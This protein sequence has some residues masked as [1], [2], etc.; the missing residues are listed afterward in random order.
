MRLRN[1]LTKRR[2]ISENYDLLC[3]FHGHLQNLYVISSTKPKNVGFQDIFIMNFVYFA[4]KTHEKFGCMLSV[5][6]PTNL[7]KI[8]Q[9]RKILKLKLK[10]TLKMSQKLSRVRTDALKLQELLQ[11]QGE[12]EKLL[13][14]LEGIDSFKEII[15]LMEGILKEHDLIADF[16]K[17]KEKKSQ[18]KSDSDREDGNKYYEKRDFMQALE[19]YNK[20]F[21]LISSGSL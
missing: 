20:R 21:D 17:F 12:Y 5:A 7:Q 11:S 1:L 13:K 10:K 18:E 3:S 9:K 6:Q 19:S 14:K 15:L 2:F 16:E 4:K 8:Q